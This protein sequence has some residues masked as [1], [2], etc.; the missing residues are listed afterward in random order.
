MQNVIRGFEDEK[1]TYQSKLNH[2]TILC[3]EKT[4]E[5]EKY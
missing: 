5:N 2:L 3:E 4:A 1:N